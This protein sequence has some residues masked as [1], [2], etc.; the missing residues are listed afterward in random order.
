MCSTTITTSLFALGE[1]FVDSLNKNVLCLGGA[2]P[3]FARELSGTFVT[4]LEGVPCILEL[5]FHHHYLR[6]SFS[7][8]G[9][10]FEIRGFCSGHVKAA[11]GVLLEPISTLPIALLRITLER[12][13]VVLELDTPDFDEPVILYQP[14]AFQ[15][16]RV[17]IN[18]LTMMMKS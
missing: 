15:F 2:S 16:R 9:S 11:Y 7:L 17:D 4:S 18:G 12:R 6:G 8:D 5:T 13:V 3:A 14:R 1:N 10:V